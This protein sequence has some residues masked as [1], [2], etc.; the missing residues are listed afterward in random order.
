MSSSESCKT[1]FVTVGTT[2]FNE[3][4]EQV[5]HPETLEILEQDDF[6]HLILQIGTGINPTLPERVNGK[7]NISWYRLKDSIA[8]DIEAASLVIS[9]AGAG[10]CMQV[11]NMAKPLLVVVNQ[12]LMG[13]HQLEL[14]Q[15]LQDDQHVLMAYPETLRSALSEF[16]TLTLEHLARLTGNVATISAHVDDSHKFA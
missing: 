12:K 14:A 16:K 3:L 2:Q 10:C 11:L 1:V 5:L 7:L 6:T 8:S 15:K 13:N 4:I 9:H